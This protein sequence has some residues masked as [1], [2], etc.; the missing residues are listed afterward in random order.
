MSPNFAYR[1]DSYIINIDD[2]SKSDKKSTEDGKSE[3]MMSQST[4]SGKPSPFVGS[5][6]DL[7]IIRPRADKKIIRNKSCDNFC[8]STI[9]LENRYRTALEYNKIQVSSRVL[10]LFSAIMSYMTLLRKYQKSSIM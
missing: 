8:E 1:S 2:K 7:H 9:F 4:I 3:E 6:S 5:M 10:T